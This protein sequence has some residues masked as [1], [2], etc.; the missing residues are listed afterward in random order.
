MRSHTRLVHLTLVR[1]SENFDT[2]ISLSV[3]AVT[4]RIY[5]NIIDGMID[6]NMVEIL[7]H[8]G[9]SI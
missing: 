7:K 2:G 6:E 8:P 9:T 3:L 4:S 1:S 5:M